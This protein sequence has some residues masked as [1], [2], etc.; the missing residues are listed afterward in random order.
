MG[1]CASSSFERSFERR[2]MPPE[3]AWEKRAKGDCSEGGFCESS[4]TP[5]A[6]RTVA[7]DVRGG[8]QAGAGHTAG[9]WGR[10]EERRGK[11]KR[12]SLE[13]LSPV[14]FCHCQC[15]CE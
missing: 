10:R 6:Q 5:D 4:V 13:V 7:H 12:T 8:G 11:D 14:C 9:E 1:T 15:A 2:G 3:R